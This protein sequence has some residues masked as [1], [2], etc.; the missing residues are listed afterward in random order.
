MTREK[1]LSALTE[2]LETDVQLSGPEELSGL[3]GWD[4][5]AVIGFMSIADDRCG[6]TLAPKK[7]N[8]C[9]TVNDLIELVVGREQLTGAGL[10]GCGENRVDSRC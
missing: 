1:L 3:S 4:S 9:A 10:A 7:I 8:S 5:M 6:I 2:L